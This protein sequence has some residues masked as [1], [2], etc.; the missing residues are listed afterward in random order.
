MQILLRYSLHEH[1]IEY[2]LW[3][4]NFGNRPFLT[5]E[6][7]LFVSAFALEYSVSILGYDISESATSQ[8]VL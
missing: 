1:E 5:I 8:C 4:R 6:H 2:D 3:R 7:P